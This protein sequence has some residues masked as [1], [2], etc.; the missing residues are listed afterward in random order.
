MEEE[1]SDYQTASAVKQAASE[2]SDPHRS[3]HD[4]RK[5]AAGVQ[6][7]FSCPRAAAL[8]NGLSDMRCTPLP[9]SRARFELSVRELTPIQP[10]SDETPPSSI[11]AQRF[12]TTLTPAASPSAAASSSRTPSCIQT[13][14]GLGVTT[15]ACSTLAA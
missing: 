14:A 9:I 2:G 13:T 12:I 3:Y 10:I 4:M 15:K 1:V 5:H 6:P 11:F 7:L 8:P